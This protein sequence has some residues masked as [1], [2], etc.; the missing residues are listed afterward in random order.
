LVAW[1]IDPTYGGE[2][3]PLKSRFTLGF[4]TGQ[5]LY[6]YGRSALSGQKG[7]QVGFE[8]RFNKS[9]LMEGRRDETELYRLNLKL[10][11]EL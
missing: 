11:W 7:Q 6:I 3:D 9:F 1:E 10:H 2:F 4:S 5:N 8:Y